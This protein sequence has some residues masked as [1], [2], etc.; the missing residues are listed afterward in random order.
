MAESPV[1]LRPVTFK[2]VV[3]VDLRANVRHALSLGLPELEWP[4]RREGCVRI[5]ANGPTAALAPR[6]R[7]LPTLAVNGALASRVALGVPPTF[8]A[9]CDPQALVTD[10]LLEPPE[11]T[12]FLVA[13]KCD[14]LVFEMLE[15]RQVVLW[16][17]AEPETFELVQ[18]RLPVRCGESI[19]SAAFDLMARMGFAAY[20]VWGWDCCYGGGE[21]HWGEDGLARIPGVSPGVISLMVGEREFI[22]RPGWAMEAQT[23][24]RDILPHYDVT[25]HGDGLVRALR[26][27]R[28]L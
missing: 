6:D 16:H 1:G 7:A 13:S 10:F 23:A 24:V 3:P 2:A 14:P 4:S 11:E 12:V 20:G 9:A 22:T 19:T 25:L 17:V 15:D 21:V 28:A 8:W 18:D 5:V 27:W 26:D